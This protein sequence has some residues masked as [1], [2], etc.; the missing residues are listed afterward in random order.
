MESPS[1]KS[2]CLVIDGFGQGGIQQAYKVLIQEY[3]LQFSAVF[4]VIIET[5]KFELELEH[6]PNFHIIRFDGKRLLDLSTFKNF[7]RKIEQINP[8]IIISNMFRS[9][10][11][12]SIAKKRNAKLIW[13]EQNTYLGR[14]KTQWLLL[15][16]LARNVNKIV[17]ISDEVCL[18]TG[19]RVNRTIE[20]IPNPITFTRLDKISDHRQ[21]DFI[22]VGRMITQK[23][24]E[25]MLYSFHTFLKDFK[26]SSKLHMVGDGVLLDSLKSLSVELKIENNCVFYG[27]KDLEEIQNLMKKSK[28]LVSTSKIEG[29]GLVRLE[30]LA[31]GCC[32]VTTKTG[33]TH[34]FQHL[35]M[36]GFIA[37]EAS[38]TEISKAMRESLSP[39][40]WT[41][42]YIH[43]RV[44]TVDLFESKAISTKLIR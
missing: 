3:C 39:K 20:L 18:Y 7:R 29:M 32:V 31:S 4:L 16:I 25:L 34:L 19:K 35:N 26:I 5:E 36:K 13:V 41:K 27:W 42:D 6:F 40:Y 33:G 11:W 23:N 22:F 21:N 17:G 38:A 28:T 15:R 8:D 9:H 43:E 44:N 12:S 37:C 1:S 24:P 2:I 10:V 30:A 14:S